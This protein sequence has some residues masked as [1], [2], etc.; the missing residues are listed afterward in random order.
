MYD[1][2]IIG[3]GI[4]GIS[5]AKEA[6]KRNKKF[7][8]LE[9]ESSFGGV[10]FNCNKNCEL[11]THKNFYEFSN[12]YSIK[13][14]LPYP[15]KNDI[16]FYLQGIINKYLLTKHVIYNTKVKNIK[17]LNNYYIVNDKFKTLNLG[18]CSGENNKI[19][20]INQ[21]KEYNG[22][23]IYNTKDFDFNQIKNKN[24]LILGNGASACDVIK[25][26]NKVD[27]QNNV[28][29][30]YKKHKYFINKYV[31]GI[32]ISYFLNNITLKFFKN[33]NLAFYKIIIKLVF[34]LFFKNTLNIPHEKMNSK[35]LVGSSIILNKINNGS[36]VYIKDNIE[37]T[38]NKN[39]IFTNNI[40]LNID[41][42]FCC[43][44]YTNNNDFLEIPKD[45]YLGIFHKDYKNIGFIGFN[46]S[47]NWPK[48]CEKQ[49]ILFL[50]FIDKKMNVNKYYSKKIINEDFT[51]Y[52]YDYLNI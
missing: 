16:L 17:K 7:L 35:N 42:I 6:K 48:I 25:N 5:L 1:L 3:F 10:W 45:R 15:N 29:C 11:Q 4:S 40:F 22:K 9:K 43:S 12:E 49:S 19:K 18:I 8:I 51:Y 32:P 13:C 20:H 27:P 36:M 41:Y 39:I 31:L 50:D 30:V 34:L 23:I 37:F 33:I 47:Y 24:T 28:I 44:G 14:D 46:P 21:L 52:L 26:I 38:N 2:I